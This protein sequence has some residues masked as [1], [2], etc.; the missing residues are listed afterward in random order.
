MVMMMAMV[1]MVVMVVILT[2]VY[3]VTLLLHRIP[4]SDQVTGCNTEVLM[5]DPRQL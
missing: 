2:S 5:L 4:H 1:M 3:Y